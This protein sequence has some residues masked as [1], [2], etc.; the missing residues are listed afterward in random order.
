MKGDLPGLSNFCAGT[1]GSCQYS[2]WRAVLVSAPP[3]P[4]PSGIVAVARVSVVR[5]CLAKPSHKP[6]PIAAARSRPAKN[7]MIAVLFFI[8]CFPLRGERERVGGVVAG[9]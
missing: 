9:A 1:I 5:L 2:G 7:A 3:L 4:A 6:P 8:S